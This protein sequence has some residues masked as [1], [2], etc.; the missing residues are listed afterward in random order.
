MSAQDVGEKLEPYASSMSFGRRY[1]R[2]AVLA[3]RNVGGFCLQM[4]GVSLFCTKVLSGTELPPR[5]SR[6]PCHSV[7]IEISHFYTVFY[8]VGMLPRC[9]ESCPVFSTI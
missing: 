4:R 5:S 1:T 6:G 9:P 7:S 3:C 2:C 8:R